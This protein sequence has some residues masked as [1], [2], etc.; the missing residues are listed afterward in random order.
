MERIGLK[1]AVSIITR[2]A[3]SKLTRRN[4]APSIITLSVLSNSEGTAKIKIK[5]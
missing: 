3:H 4:P 5:S 2:K 1:I